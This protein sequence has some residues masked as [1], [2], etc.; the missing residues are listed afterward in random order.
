MLSLQVYKSL[1][2]VLSPK[3]AS[4][5]WSV[6]YSLG[7]IAEWGCRKKIKIRNKVIVNS[8]TIGIWKTVVI[9]LQG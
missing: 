7:N 5:T 8:K 1:F 9:Y 3:A 6:L 4:P 2:Y